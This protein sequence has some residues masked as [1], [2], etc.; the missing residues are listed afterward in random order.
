MKRYAK[1]AL[2]G[3]SLAT[4][5]GAL[6]FCRD[7]RQQL[8][9]TDRQV[10]NNSVDLVTTDMWS[11]DALMQD[12]QIEALQRAKESLEMRLQF[13]EKAMPRFGPMGPPLPPL[14]FQT[15]PICTN[16]GPLLTPVSRP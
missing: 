11:R 1:K 6:A 13:L 9:A 8:T 15:N 7:I 16:Y 2:G 12:E 4:V 14:P 5:I 10:Q 3:L